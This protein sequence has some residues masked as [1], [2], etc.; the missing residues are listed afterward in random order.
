MDPS[1]ETQPNPK[2]DVI[3][4]NISQLMAEAERMLH[5]STSQHAEEQIELLRVRCDSLQ[6][7]FADFFGSA[8]R[9][10][11]AGAQRVDRRIRARPYETLGIVFGAGIL[12]G[13]ILGR[14]KP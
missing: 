2:V 7:H 13:A 14:R 1:A 5:D 8:G 11:A 10:L 3:I 12:C 4:A 6:A 9:T